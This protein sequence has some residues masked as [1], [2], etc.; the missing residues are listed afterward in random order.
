[1]IPP[2]DMVALCTYT[3]RQQR[4]GE[5][6][7]SPATKDGNTTYTPRQ[8]YCAP[9]LGTICSELDSDVRL[10]AVPVLDLNDTK[11]TNSKQK[12]TVRMDNLCAPFYTT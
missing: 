2:G 5:S 3:S 6:S 12:Q 1:M 11:R 10:C 4:S 9:L 8:D 7:L